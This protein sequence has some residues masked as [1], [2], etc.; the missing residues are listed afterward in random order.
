MTMI[1]ESVEQQ[2]HWKQLVFERF[3]E[4]LHA[5]YGDFEAI[6]NLAHVINEA[7]SLQQAIAFLSTSPQAKYAI[8]NRLPLGAVDLQQLQELPQET[9]G[10]RYSDHMLRNHLK[11]IVTQPV[12]SD[13]NYVTTHMAEIHDIWHVMI[14]ADVDMPG[15]MKLHA[16]TAAQFRYA[17]FSFAMLAKNLMKAA[18]D[19]LELAEEWMNAM[20]EGWVMGKRAQTLFGVQWQTLWQVPVKELRAEWNI[21]A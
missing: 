14:D 2:Q 17:R 18:V 21:L 9:L 10:D 1:Q 16:F 5:P 3:L 20:T 7:E 8:Q 4:I 19:D 15:E 13:L 12:E 6:G 11:P